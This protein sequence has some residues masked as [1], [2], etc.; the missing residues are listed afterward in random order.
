MDVSGSVQSLSSL[1]GF[2]GTLA[3]G[4][5]VTL[6]NVS[7]LSSTATTGA[8]VVYSGSELNSSTVVD[9]LQWGGERWHHCACVSVWWLAWVIGR[10]CEWLCVK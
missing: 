3:P 7:G 5:S 9:A 2:S 10:Q 6:S 8:V 4:E 1:T